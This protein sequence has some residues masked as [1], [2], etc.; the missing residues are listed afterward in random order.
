MKTSPI[1]NFGRSTLNNEVLNLGRESAERIDGLRQFQQS[2]D[3]LK[4]D[5]KNLTEPLAGL[6]RIGRVVRDDISSNSSS[7]SIGY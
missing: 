4:K 6:R 7:S 5:E 1:K 2:M 3:L